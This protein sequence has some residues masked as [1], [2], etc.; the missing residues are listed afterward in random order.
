MPNG[1]DIE[2]SLHGRLNT[3]FV[4][5]QLHYYPNLTST[6][7]MA[8]KLAREGAGEGSVVITDEQ[9]SGRGRLGRVWLSPKGSL[10][11]SIVLRPYLNRLPQLVMVSSLA[12]VRA[13][14]EVADLESQIKWPND[15]LIENKK[16]CGIL[17]ENEVKGDKVNFAVVGIG[18]NVNL[19]P[20]AFPDISAI[21]T[22]LSQ[23]RGK[24]IS[25]TELTSVLLSELEQLYLEAQAGAPVYREWQ[26]HLDTLGKWIQVRIG[27]SVE[28]GRAETVTEN[29]NLILRRA[30]GIAVEIIAGDVTV[31]KN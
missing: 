7:D 18:I 21:A 3:K 26:K 20:S 15:I 28:Q 17:V 12:V 16:V 25:K 23:Q 14:R 13:I 10:A 2:A 1:S 19:N 27:K 4:G 29:G 8:K 5:Q 30:N 9:T 6:M 22:S 31:I 24:E 11:M